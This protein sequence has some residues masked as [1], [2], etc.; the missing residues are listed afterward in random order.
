MTPM[1][2][3]PGYPTYPQKQKS[4]IS[5]ICWILAIAAVLLAIFVAVSP[6]F[7]WFSM[8]A[9]GESEKMTLGELKKEMADSGKPI[10]PGAGIAFIIILSVFT[11]ILVLIPNKFTA[12]GSVVTAFAL[13]LLGIILPAHYLG[14]LKDTFS[15]YMGELGEYGA[16]FG[17]LGISITGAGGYFICIIFS[18]LVFLLAAVRCILLWKFQNQPKRNMY[19]Y[20]DYS[21]AG[22]LVMP[23]A[24]QMRNPTSFC[25]NCGTKVAPGA[26]FCGTCGR[27][28]N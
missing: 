28:L 11:S 9:L 5:T 13:M 7:K 21:L 17:E 18:I 12:A 24:E 27:D 3:Y 8:N 15:S 2:P 22:D 23:T 25:P 10:H 19:P 14:V 6:A 20:P 26:R 1:P 16:L 4:S